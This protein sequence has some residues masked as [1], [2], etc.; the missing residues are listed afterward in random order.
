MSGE[1]RSSPLQTGH[2]AR[3]LI[4]TAQAI[5]E[6]RWYFA[7]GSSRGSGAQMLMTLRLAASPFAF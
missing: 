4:K 3:L 1:F 5:D 6:L 2:L 7:A